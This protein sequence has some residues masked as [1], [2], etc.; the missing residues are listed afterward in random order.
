MCI[1]VA[2]AWSKIQLNLNFLP[3]P[4]PNDKLSMHFKKT[5]TSIWQCM[6]DASKVLD[7]F[8][9]KI[10]WA[11]PLIVHSHFYFTYNKSLQTIDNLAKRT[12][13]KQNPLVWSAIA[14]I[15][16][17]WYCSPT[18]PVYRQKPNYIEQHTKDGITHDMPTTEFPRVCSKLNSIRLFLV[19][20]KNMHFIMKI[21]QSIW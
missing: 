17:T 4:L 11:L 5:L 15:K 2:F 9:S 13:A 16:H 21:L 3:F 18:R 8:T 14:N 1:R 12:L 20:S 7:P 6:H 10:G 19:C